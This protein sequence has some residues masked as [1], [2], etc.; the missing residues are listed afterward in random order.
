MRPATENEVWLALAA[1]STWPVALTTDAGFV[2][3]AADDR[4]ADRISARLGGVSR[5]VGE[6][7]YVL[8]LAARLWGATL[9]CVVRDG[10]LPDPAA[11]LRR[12]T[13][14]AVQ[15][16]MSRYEGWR[17]VTPEQLLEKVVA[18]LTP[19]IE[20]SRLSTRLM[21]GNVAS[22]LHAAPRVLELPAA[23]PWA[24]EMLD[25]LPLKGEMVGDRRATCCLFYEV[26]GG[27]LCA[28]C[29]LRRV[30]ARG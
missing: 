10:V 30:P 8:G 19:V 21:W 12:D 9:G 11:L 28:D 24:A 26:P 14:G 29:V 27:G 17:D 5:R 4:I 25:M 1:P 6:S 18:A 23:R 7:T 15:L 22:A 13:E 3:L 20:R 2:P 16:G